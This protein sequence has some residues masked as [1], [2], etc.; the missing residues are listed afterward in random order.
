[1]TRY[2]FKFTGLKVSETAEFAD[3]S[4]NELRVIQVLSDMGGSASDDELT[5]RSGIS[6]ARLASSL[7]FWQEA[8]VIIPCEDEPVYG[9]KI[10]DEFPERVILGEPMEES[11]AEVASTIRSHKLASLFDEIA[12]MIGKTMLTP[13]E[14][15][16]I[17][18]LSSQYGLGEEYIATLAAHLHGKGALTVRN[19][20]AGA[21]KMADNGIFTVDELERAIS[22]EER[23]R[24]QFIEYRRIFGIHN[25]SFSAKEREYLEKW[26]NAYAYGTEII[27]MAYD[28]TTIKTGGMSFAYMD[29]LLTDWSTAGC[30]TLADCEKRYEAVQINKEK[31]AK[32][33]KKPQRIDAQK[34]KKDAPR[35]GDFDPEEA[36]RLAVERSYPAGKSGGDN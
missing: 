26:G 1:M 29:K 7:A 30:R 6:R 24:V 27:A 5:E 9:N 10:V 13:M 21:K 12:A 31:E 28:I 17:A 33:K 4:L 15:K 25:R 22:E 2:N 23:T 20:A 8:G 32:E 3:A 14:M 18:A 34:P 16:N 36:F 19:L 35:Y 11:A